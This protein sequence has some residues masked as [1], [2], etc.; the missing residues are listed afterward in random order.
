MGWLL[1]SSFVV[2]GVCT[3]L[4]DR[5]TKMLENESSLARDAEWNNYVDKCIENKSSWGSIVDNWKGFKL[6]TYRLELLYDSPH[7]YYKG[8]VII[9]ERNW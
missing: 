4:Y 6:E 5:Y 2:L 9:T 3:Y 1:M 8:K 7:E